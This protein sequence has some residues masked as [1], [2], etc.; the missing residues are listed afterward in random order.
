MPDPS[1]IHQTLQSLAA[2]ET[3]SEASS[4][5]LFEHLLSGGLDEPQIGAVLALIASRSPTT[6][7]LVGAARVMRAHVTPVPY[8]AAE[9]ERLI[10]TCGTGG[11]PKTFNVST[12][13]A[14]IAAGIEPPKAGGVRRVVVAKHGNRSRTGRG[15]AEVLAALGVN[16]DATPDTQAA[17]LAEAGVCFSFAVLHHPAM[18]YAAGPRRSLGFPTIFNLLGPLTNPAGATRQLLGVARAEQVGLAA[19]ALRALGAERAGVAHSDDGLDELGVTAPTTIAWVDRGAVQTERLDPTDNALGLDQRALEGATLESL[20]ASDVE[21]A[22]RAA[23]AVIDGSDTGARRAIALVNAGAAAVVAGVAPD[24]PAGVA[25]AQD[26]IDSGRAAG[27]L[28][29]LARVSHAG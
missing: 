28:Q 12:V 29:S 10:D 15:S 13:A 8:T 14:I 6:D 17:C 26:A 2:G 23:R 16:I 21:D 27:V 3:L 18:R 24:M 5:A 20:R 11:A 9:D 7:E 25:L 4:S 19:D 1:E 22:A